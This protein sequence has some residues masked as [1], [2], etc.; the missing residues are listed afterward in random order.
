MTNAQNSTAPHEVKPD[1]VPVAIVYQVYQ[2][3]RVTLAPS[4][5]LTCDCAQYETNRKLYSAECDHTRLVLK[6]RHAHPECWTH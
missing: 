1:V 5:I 2:F 6:W 3:A 4:G